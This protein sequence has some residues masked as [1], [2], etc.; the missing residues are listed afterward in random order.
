[1]SAFSDAE[2]LTLASDLIGAEQYDVFSIIASKMFMVGANRS[3][4]IL[5][6]YR[7][8]SDEERAVLDS[9]LCA[10]TGYPF[11]QIVKIARRAE[12]ANEK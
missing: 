4:A 1:M 7:R 9:L 3:E 10:M 6:L 8:G 5:N 12:K 11:S 2:G